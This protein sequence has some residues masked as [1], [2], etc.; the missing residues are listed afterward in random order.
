MTMLL[1]RFGETNKIFAECAIVK[2]ERITVREVTGRNMA[3]TEIK[4]SE[5]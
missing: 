2:A 4:L 3:K 5:N 1:D